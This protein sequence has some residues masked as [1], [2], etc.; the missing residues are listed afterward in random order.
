MRQRQGRRE[1]AVRIAPPHGVGAAALVARCLPLRGKVRLCRSATRAQAWP[2]AAAAISPSGRKTASRPRWPSFAHE[3]GVPPREGRAS[4]RVEPDELGFAQVGP[5]V[6]PE[7]DRCHRAWRWQALRDAAP[8][9]TRG[10]T[11]VSQGRR[12]NLAPLHAQSACRA[13]PCT[14]IRPEAGARPTF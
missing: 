6:G 5:D 8:H 10:N 14:R 1:G 2:T 9:Q 7:R 3:D 12:E 4:Q 13:R 11:A